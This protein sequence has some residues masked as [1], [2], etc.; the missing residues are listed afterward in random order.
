MPTRPRPRRSRSRAGSSSTTPS[1]ARCE[2]GLKPGDL[3]PG[4]GE[5][6]V[7][8]TP[9]RTAWQQ[10]HLDP[11]SRQLLARDSAAFVHQSLSTPCLA[12]IVRAQ[13]LYIEDLSGRRYMDFHGN[14]VHHLGHGHPE[15]IAAIKAQL[16]ELSFAPRRFAPLRAVELAE[17]LGEK[18]RG[19]TGQPGRVLF[20]TGGSDALEVALKLARAATG[21]FKTLSFWDSFHGAGFGASSVGGE[22]LFRSGRL[23]PLLP[24][25]EHVAPFGCYRCAYG[26]AVDERGQPDLATCKLAC[27]AMV[28][29]VLEREGDV[30]AVVAEPARAVPYIPPPGY[31][32][33]VQ[34][35]CQ[36]H[37][38]LL[39]FD[40]IPTGL[41]KTGR[42]FAAEHDQVAPD[43]V[44]LG[45]A[46]G[47]GVLPIAACIARD[48]LNMATDFALGHYTHEKNPVMAA[49]ALATLDVI[50][51]DDLVANAERVGRQALERLHAMKERH[52]LIGDVR[53][54]GLLLGL[55]LVEQRSSKVPARAA[56]E[57]VLYR[58]LS[59]GLSFKTTMGNVITL[60]PPLT[61]TPAQMSQALDILDDCLAEEAVH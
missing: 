53:G 22:A 33:A 37:G 48:G 28:R 61:I 15:V 19:L 50:E 26:H 5:G 35:A 25:S 60:T 20:T 30:A 32:Q 6:D 51:R 3:P 34:Q 8:G 55:E 21:R 47:G 18:F 46:L 49:A 31:W 2:A 45:K 41:G 56:A 24:G 1:T 17:R 38:T 14:N 43:I 40:E 27:A 42:F 9:L 54:R 58:A 29:Y 4:P 13:G 59:R 57:R 11:A 10:Q 23:G 7:N 16:D 39:I 52:S 44:V 12:P 36:E